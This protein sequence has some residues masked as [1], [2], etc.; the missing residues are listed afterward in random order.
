MKNQDTEFQEKNSFIQTRPL[1]FK[2]GY[3]IWGISDERK[4]EVDFLLI[5]YKLKRQA[6]SSSDNGIRSYGSPNKDVVRAVK[7]LYKECDV[8]E[9]DAQGQGNN[10]QQYNEV[11]Q[12]FN[13]NEEASE[14]S[15]ALLF[16]PEYDHEV[17]QKATVKEENRLRKE[18]RKEKEQKKIEKEQ[19]ELEKMKVRFEKLK[20]QKLKKLNEI[21]EKKVLTNLIEG[22]KDVSLSKEIVSE[23]NLLNP[24]SFYNYANFPGND[25]N[26]QGIA[27]QRHHQENIFREI[28]PKYFQLGFFF[29]ACLDSLDQYCKVQVLEQNI[30]PMNYI[31][32]KY[33]DVMGAIDDY[34]FP[35]SINE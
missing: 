24:E 33:F 4:E 29:L 7:I 11:I 26:G 21:E 23:Y 12:E 28:M 32:Q 27:L 30:K 6:S 19:R 20:K 16:Q 13:I 2:P 10:Q 22:V 5:D 25:G 14:Q 34:I 3:D 8:H 18:K 9:Q 1:F 15:H 17:I 31:C 35:G